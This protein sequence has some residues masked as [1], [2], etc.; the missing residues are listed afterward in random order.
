[1]NKKLLSL[2]FASALVLSACGDDSG[3]EERTETE[4]PSEEAE[5]S[6]ETANSLPAEEIGEGEFY[7][8]NGSGSS[9]DTDVVEFYDEELLTPFLGI[10][11]WGMDGSHKTF[12]Y[13]NGDLVAEEQLS[14]SQ[15]QID[16]PQEHYNV[17]THTV[18]AI[19]YED[20]TEDSEPIFVRNVD[21]EIQE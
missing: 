15:G 6:E 13:I 20:N 10:E 11:G 18:T 7:I 4:Q 21:F 3:T 14:D 9:E 16:I 1:M 19:Q 12:I 8:V 2:L 5:T 17:G